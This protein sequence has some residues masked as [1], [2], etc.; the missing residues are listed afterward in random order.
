M[1]LL[2]LMDRTV[3]VPR[4][5]A[6]VADFVVATDRAA[7]LTLAEVADLIDID[8]TDLFDDE[9]YFLGLLK[10]VG[11]RDAVEEDPLPLKFMGGFL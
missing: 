7:V 5:R 6:V 11:D 10:L 4:E 2:L 9:T 8:P 3:L 1:D